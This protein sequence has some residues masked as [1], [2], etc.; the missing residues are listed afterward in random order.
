MGLATASVVEAAGDPVTH[1]GDHDAEHKHKRQKID[2]TGAGQAD[3]QA[4]S[5]DGEHVCVFFP[6]PR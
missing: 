1:G 6:P 2:T 5:A 3:G 4:A